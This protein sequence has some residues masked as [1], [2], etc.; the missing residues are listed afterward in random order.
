MLWKLYYAEITIKKI[1]RKLASKKV[2]IDYYIY[3][4]NLLLL[5]IIYHHTI[6]YYYVLIKQV[7][8]DIY[9]I[10]CLVVDCQNLKT[11]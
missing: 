11:I 4:I 7:Q 8:V 1:L 2:S 3:Y 5:I 9:W 10:S 6:I